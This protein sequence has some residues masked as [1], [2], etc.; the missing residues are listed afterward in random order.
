VRGQSVAARDGDGQLV[1]PDDERLSAMW[2]TAG[3]TGTPVWWHVADPLAF[4]D[5]VDERNEFLELLLE[6]PDWSFAGP[7]F[8]SFERLLD[9]LETVV[10]A[11]PGTTFV[12]VHAGCCAEDLGRVGRML[13]TYP[14]VVADTGARLA[15]LGRVPRA[16]RDL[17]VRHPD[18]FLFGTD[19]APTSAPV[20]SVYRRAF[21]TSDEAFAY[22]ADPDEAPTQGRWPIAGLDL[23]VDVLGALYSGN[24]RRLFT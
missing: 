15:E 11:H 24:A 23:P 21:E 13:D 18:R 1:L 2:D 3:E 7:Q 10:E 5:P 14:N 12:A 16:A 9:S 8:P 20:V 19:D 4:F 17:L 22:D 6:R